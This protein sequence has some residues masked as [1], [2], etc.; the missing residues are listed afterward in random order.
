MTSWIILPVVIGFAAA[1]MLLVLN[2]LLSELGR[3]LWQRIGLW[4]ATTCVVILTV[5]ELETG[6]PYTGRHVDGNDTFLLI[7]AKTVWRLWILV[8]ASYAW[9]KLR[10]EAA[11]RRSRCRLKLMT[12][13]H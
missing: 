10:V 2:H 13:Q 8:F 7:T 11:Q 1:A 9:S 3:P 4:L 6:C 5:A 12:S